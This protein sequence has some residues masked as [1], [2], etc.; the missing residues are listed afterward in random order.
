MCDWPEAVDC[1][2][3]DM[4]NS[5]SIN[6]IVDDEKEDLLSHKNPILAGLSLTESFKSP[7]KK[8]RVV[9]QPAGSVLLSMA[10]EDEELGK[11]EEVRV[12]FVPKNKKKHQKLLDK[13]FM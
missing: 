7:G 4:K 1:V 12:K 8:R 10:G 9:G 5:I 2:Q 11:Q 3:V 6:T 13:Y